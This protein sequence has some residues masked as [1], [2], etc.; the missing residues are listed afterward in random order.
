VEKST[1]DLLKLRTEHQ[2]KCLHPVLKVQASDETY[3]AYK[4]LIPKVEIVCANCGFC[5]AKAGTIYFNE[6]TTILGIL[7][8]HNPRLLREVL[9]KTT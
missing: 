2:R 4:G 8:E 6:L 3:D 1:T 9:D 5:I 7:W